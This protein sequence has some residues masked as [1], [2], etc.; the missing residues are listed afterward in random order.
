MTFVTHRRRIR[1][2]W[3]DCDPVGIVL[4]RRLFEHF[5]TSSWSL[6]QA[7]LGVAPRDLAGT[8]DII[9][10]PLVD[11]RVHIER[12]LMFGDMVDIASTI[13]AFRRSS[14]DV[15]HRLYLGPDLLVEGRETRVWAAA[16]KD[17][18]TRLASH[19]IPQDV[20]ERFKSS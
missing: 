2:E 3:A 10:I 13:G 8:F 12:P 11:V 9:G 1:I 20:I 14:F 17:D 16:D 4:A 5:D 18:P 15:E 6:F 19:P 7:V